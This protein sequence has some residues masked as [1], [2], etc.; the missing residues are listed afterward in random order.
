MKT[1]ALQKQLD[2][3]YLELSA[4][5]A[6]KGLVDAW[7]VVSARL[8]DDTNETFLCHINAAIKY[9]RVNKKHARILQ[10]FADKHQVVNII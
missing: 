2:N 3:H 6:S 7:N 9:G 8:R 10:D 4:N 5:D 1:S